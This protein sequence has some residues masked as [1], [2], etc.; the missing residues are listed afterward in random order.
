ML[1]LVLLLSACAAA[2]TSAPDL[3]TGSPASA[4][5]LRV[6][7]KRITLPI[8]QPIRFRAVE[9]GDGLVPV[10]VAWTASGGTIRPDG[11][12]LSAKPGTFKITGRARGRNNRAD[13]SVVLVVDPDAPNQV[14]LELVPGTTTLAPGATVAFSAQA[15]MSDN[16][17]AGASLL[18]TAAGGTISESGVYTAGS[19]AGSFDVIARDTISGLA[20]TSAVT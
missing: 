14:A 19:T 1:S 4:L 11:T 16:T 7:P 9:S 20:D 18:W 2:D 15:R 17:S 8:N 6:S 5:A 12:F 13:T 3:P 10:G